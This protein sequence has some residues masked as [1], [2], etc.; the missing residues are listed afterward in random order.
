MDRS[1]VL[2]LSGKHKVRFQ[3]NMSCA[4]LNKRSQSR[5][6]SL[7]KTQI[8]SYHTRDFH[9]CQSTPAAVHAN[10]DAPN[11]IQKVAR[12]HSIPVQASAPGATCRSAMNAYRYER[13]GVPRKAAYVMMPKLRPR[14]LAPHTADMMLGLT[15]RVL[16]K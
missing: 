15:S 6:R 1:L 7:R 10:S 4:R 11:E 8:H 13:L 5:N 2:W 3:G 14:L 12:Q 9:R 16:S